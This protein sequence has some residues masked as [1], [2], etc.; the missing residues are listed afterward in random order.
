MAP[1]ESPPEIR[2]LCVIIPLPSFG[3]EDGGGADETGVAVVDGRRANAS[4]SL[5]S[6]PADVRERSEDDD[7]PMS[8]DVTL[9]VV[10]IVGVAEVGVAPASRS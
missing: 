2:L 4:L 1:F 5:S 8:D 7:C 10:V 6:S 9:G 3:L